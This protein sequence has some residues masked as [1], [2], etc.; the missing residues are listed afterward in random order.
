MANRS[1]PASG[2]RKPERAEGEPEPG[3]ATIAEIV[4]EVFVP[5]VRP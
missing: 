5:L 3:T 4:D 2:E 1:G